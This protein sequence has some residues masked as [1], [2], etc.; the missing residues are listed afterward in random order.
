MPSK[1]IAKQ[2]VKDLFSEF[3][4]D[5]VEELGGKFFYKCSRISGGPLGEI[6]ERNEKD[7]EPVPLSL[8]ADLSLYTTDELEHMLKITQSERVAHKE[9]ATGRNLSVSKK[10]IKLKGAKV[11]KVKRVQQFMAF[12]K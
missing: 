6:I 1:F 4:I 8:D 11:P 5:S 12:T 9:S 3:I 7:L 10:G 2:R